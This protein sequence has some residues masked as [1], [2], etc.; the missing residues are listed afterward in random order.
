M[1]DRNVNKL[2]F[3]CIF[4][5]ATLCLSSQNIGNRYPYFQN[6]YLDDDNEWDIDEEGRIVNRFE[7]TGRDT[8]FIIDEN[9]NRMDEKS[10]SFEPGTVIKQVTQE[11]YYNDNGQLI[12]DTYDYYKMNSDENANEFFKFLAEN[13]NVE[14]SQMQ[15]IDNKYMEHNYVSTSHHTNAEHSSINILSQSNMTNLHLITHIHNHPGLANDGYPS[16]MPGDACVASGD[17][18]FAQTDT[19]KEMNKR[20]IHQKYDIN[21]PKFFIYKAPNEKGESLFIRYDHKSKRSDFN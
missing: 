9:G 21:L 3:F 7:N 11:Y 5:F 2:I 1:K 19:I 8:F 17:I 15:L 16:G 10:I 6:E 13:T 14:W 4:F 12:I 20:R 18:R